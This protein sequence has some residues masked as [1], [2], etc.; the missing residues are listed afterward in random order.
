MLFSEKTKY[1]PISPKTG[2]VFEKTEK[3]KR[4]Q[5]RG[6]QHLDAKRIYNMGGSL[7]RACAC[8]AAGI[9]QGCGI[10]AGFVSKS[11]RDGLRRAGKRRISR[12]HQKQICRGRVQ[13]R[14]VSSDRQGSRPAG[15]SDSAAGFYRGGNCGLSQIYRR[16]ARTGSAAAGALS[17]GKAAPPHGERAGSADGKHPFSDDSR[18]LCAAYGAV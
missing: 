13:V 12:A 10:Y 11:V 9:G 2:C 8:H 15:I 7:P 14:A 1:F 18:E 17:R 6:K 5:A 4:G 16:R 3:R